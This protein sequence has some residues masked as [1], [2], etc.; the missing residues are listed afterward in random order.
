MAVHGE[1]T[2]APPAMRSG[3]LYLLAVCVPA[4]LVALAVAQP[5]V[6][7]GSLFGDPASTLGTDPLTGLISTFAD[8]VWFGAGLTC[9]FAATLARSARHAAFLCTAGL[10]SM[11]LSLDDFYLLHEEILP[12]RVGIPERYVKAFYLVGTFGYVLAFRATMRELRWP[13]LVLA[14]ACF[15]ASLVADSPAVGRRLAFLPPEVMFYVVEDGLKVAG[16]FLWAAFHLDAA[17]RL[18]GAVRS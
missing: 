9:L 14:G 4:I 5:W 10:L 2:P 1:W 18:V 17:R 3:W 8:L 7:P 6:P 11:T 16:I 15:A 12:D 13:A